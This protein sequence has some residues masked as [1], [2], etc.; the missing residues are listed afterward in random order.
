MSLTTAKKLIA[1][2]TG[3]ETVVAL[4]LKGSTIAATGVIGSDT[5]ALNFVD[6]DSVVTGPVVDASG[7]TL[8]LSAGYPAY[9]AMGP[10][11]IQI[12]KGTTSGACGVWIDR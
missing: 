8:F 5:I 4:V 3:A 7:V 10:A 12:V 6:I 2:A 1:N 11:R 9:T